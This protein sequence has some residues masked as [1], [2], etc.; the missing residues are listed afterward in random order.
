MPIIRPLWFRGREVA[1]GNG[2]FVVGILNVTPDSFSDGGA[3]ST[4]EDA[5]AAGLHMAEAGA[6]AIDVGGESTRPGS[7]PVSADE[8]IR[9]TQP[10]ISKL[11]ER[12]GSEGPSICIDTRSAAV[13]RAALEA[14]A[15]V[16]NDV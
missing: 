8:Q 1:S 7:Q 5:L 10:V 16:V 14:G 12:F 15:T 11:A 6:D 13:A 4:T 2:P 9:R 3:Y